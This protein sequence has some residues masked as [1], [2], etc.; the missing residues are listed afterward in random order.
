MSTATALGIGYTPTLTGTFGDIT[1]P[2]HTGTP[3]KTVADDVVAGEP[4]RVIYTG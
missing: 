4:Y 3:T 2:I 1:K